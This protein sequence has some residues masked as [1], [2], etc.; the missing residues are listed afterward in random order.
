MNCYPQK[1]TAVD[2]YLV[3]AVKNLAGVDVLCVIPKVAEVTN[4]HLK[5]EDKV[6][7][8]ILRRLR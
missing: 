3:T 1:E 4:I 7:D 5:L 2:K 6:V 8:K